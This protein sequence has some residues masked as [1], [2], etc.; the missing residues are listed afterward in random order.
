MRRLLRDAIRNIN[1]APDP[2]PPFLPPDHPPPITST[3][4]ITTSSTTSNTPHALGTLSCLPPEIR[5][6]ILV[7]AFGSRTLHL[8]LR[9]AP[10]QRRRDQLFT[11]AASGLGGGSSPAAVPEHRLHG[12]GHGH[13]AGSAPLDPKSPAAAAAA[14]PRDTSARLEWHWYGGVCHRLPPRGVAYQPGTTRGASTKWPHADACLRGSAPLC[15]LWLSP[16]P[17]R[18]SKM[19]DVGAAAAAPCDANVGALG[20]LRTCRQAYL[21]GVEVLYG[22]NTFCIESRD[23]IDMLLMDPLARHH[24]SDEH[25]RLPVL[26]PAHHLAIITT[27]ELRL[28]VALFNGPPEQ[29]S[30]GTTKTGAELARPRSRC[31]P[32]LAS[33]A[34]VLPGLRSLVVSFSGALYSS[35]V[36]SADIPAADLEAVLLEPL[37]RALL[38]TLAASAALAALTTLVVEL[39][40][41]VFE[42]IVALDMLL[43]ETVDGE[44]DPWLRYPIPS[45]RSSHNHAGLLP[46]SLSEQ[47]DSSCVFYYYIKKGVECWDE[48]DIGNFTAFR[49]YC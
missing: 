18:G 6:R 21:E 44:S 31:L 30:R 23:F 7:L 35:R 28:E 41:N 13:G 42:N 48:A 47:N 4:S 38:P 46:P 1:S 32:R 12:R 16:P 15:G 5:R 37:A 8:D 39:P 3:P 34:R 25:G 40:S 29:P 19:E 9:L 14:E 45:L 43:Q 22:T 49:E 2:P 26:L 33:L 36:S 27:L 24:G 11:A 17:Q 20:W 10:R